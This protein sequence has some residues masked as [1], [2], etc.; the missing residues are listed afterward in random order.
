MSL[1]FN[2]YISDISQISDKK[3]SESKIKTND[4]KVISQKNKQKTNSIILDDSNAEIIFE[5]LNEDK[6]FSGFKSQLQSLQKK[7]ESDTRNFA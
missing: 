7:M 6:M 1:S 2:D 3:P 4:L 5:E